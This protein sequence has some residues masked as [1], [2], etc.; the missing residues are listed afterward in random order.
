MYHSMKRVIVV[1]L[2]LTI[3]AFPVYGQEA[4]A[5]GDTYTFESGASFIIPAGAEFDAD[6]NAPRAVISRLE[7]DIFLIMDFYDPAF[8][9]VIFGANTANLSFS[10]AIDGLVSVLDRERPPDEAVIISDTA[11]GRQGI[12]LTFDEV[13]DGTNIKYYYIITRFSSDELGMITVTTGEFLTDEAVDIVLDAVDSFNVGMSVMVFEGDLVTLENGAFITVPPGWTIN[14]DGFLPM[15]TLE[16]PFVIVDILEPFLMDERLVDTSRLE[17]T[18]VLRYLLNLFEYPDEIQDGDM[19]SLESTLDGRDILVFD[20]LNP[21]DDDLPQTLLVV[22]M[23]DSTI[24][25]LNAQP[26]EVLDDDT[27]M[28]LYTLADSFDVPMDGIASVSASELPNYYEYETGTFFRYTD[29]FVLD[30]EL[31]APF[32]S[33]VWSGQVVV[34][35]LDPVLLDLSP[36]MTLEELL[37]LSLANLPMTPNDLIQFNIGG[38]TI[39]FATGE[40]DLEGERRVFTM[41]YVP[42]DNGLF[43]VMELL[44]LDFLRDDLLDT[45]LEIAGS[46]NSTTF[47]TGQ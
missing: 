13:V 37:E 31:D 12:T 40:G 28:M 25:A 2:C 46:F 43:G 22:R 24:G 38:R 17:L 36:E 20:F 32:A 35:M 27:F 7:D 11:D 15:L 29:D 14:T 3:F 41:V 30:E 6:R 44:S 21:N 5:D 26:D 42:F 18:T 39:T 10:E 1:V 47:S 8:L 16:E 34:T 33:L 19:L 4:D 45:V 23:S 9:E